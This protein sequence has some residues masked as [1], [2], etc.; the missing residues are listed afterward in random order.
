MYMLD[1][2]LKSVMI[3]CYGITDYISFKIRLPCSFNTCKFSVKP[4]VKSKYVCKY[5]H[6]NNVAH[7]P[8]L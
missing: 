5:D 8:S 4:K 7:T 6:K 3:A 2:T 1:K